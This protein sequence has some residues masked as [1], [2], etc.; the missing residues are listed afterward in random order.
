MEIVSANGRRVMV[1]RDVDV[2]FL[3]RIVQA[4]ETLR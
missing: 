4:L 1:G 2:A 3:L